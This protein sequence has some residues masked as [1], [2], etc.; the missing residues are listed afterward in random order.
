MSK[1][2]TPKLWQQAE[3]KRVRGVFKTIS[4]FS[5]G[6][7]VSKLL[8]P[9]NWDNQHEASWAV[10]ETKTNK[11]CGAAISHPWLKADCGLALLFPISPFPSLDSSS[12]A[13]SQTLLDPPLQD[14]FYEHWEIF[15]CSRYPAVLSVFSLSPIPV[16]FIQWKLGLLHARFKLPTG[17]FPHV[18]L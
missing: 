14:S 10:S 17:L 9:D 12:S 8:Y 3:N 4:H 7:L 11:R 2:E 6:H 16:N 13:V 15:T 18:I 5:D 1:L